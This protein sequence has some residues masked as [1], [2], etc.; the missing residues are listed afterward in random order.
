MFLK[1]TFSG[2]LNFNRQLK[3]CLVEY[4]EFRGLKSFKKSLYFV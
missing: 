2:N 4:V 3:C 1:Y